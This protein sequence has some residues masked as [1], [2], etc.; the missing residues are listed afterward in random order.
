MMTW[1]SVSSTLC[2]P[3]MCWTEVSASSSSSFLL[4][5]LKEKT[6]LTVD[7]GLTTNTLILFPVNSQTPHLAPQQLVE[8]K[9]NRCPAAGAPSRWPGWRSSGSWAQGPGPSRRSLRRCLLPGERAAYLHGTRRETEFRKPPGSYA[10][11]QPLMSKNRFYRK[12]ATTHAC[13]RNQ[14]E[15]RVPADPSSLTSREESYVWRCV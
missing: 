15:L 13:E 7:A 9:L 10:A 11:P 3:W 2:E 14:Y 8:E 1:T 12:Y 4:S 6:T 5:H